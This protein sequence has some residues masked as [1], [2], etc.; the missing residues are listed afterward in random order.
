MKL[1]ITFWQGDERFCDLCSHYHAVGYPCHCPD[2]R[3]VYVPCRKHP[4]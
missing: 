4:S 3:R 1:A 2:L